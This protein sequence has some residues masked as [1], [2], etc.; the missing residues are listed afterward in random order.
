[1]KLTLRKGLIALL[2]AVCAVCLALGVAACGD[3]NFSE[4]WSYDNVGHWHACTD[5]G[6]DEISGYAEH[7]SVDEGRVVN[8]VVYYTCSICGA[9]YSSTSYTYIV[10]IKNI[11]NAGVSDVSVTLTDSTGATVATNTSAT[12]GTVRFRGLD[13]GNYTATIDEDTIP[14]GYSYDEEDLT[15]NFTSDY[16]AST[17]YLTPHVITADEAEEPSG[18]TYSLGSIVYDHTFTVYYA[19]GTGPVTITLSEYLEKYDMVVLQ[20]FYTTCSPCRQEFPY[21]NE[22]YNSTA[23]SLGTYYYSSVGLIEL[24]YA[25]QDSLSAMQAFISGEYG[26]ANMAY[27]LDSS[28]YANHKVSAY[29]TTVV[30]DRY[31]VVCSWDDGSNPTRSYWINLFEKYIGDDYTPDYV[32]TTSGSDEVSE[33][34]K[35]TES[36]PESG[37]IASQIVTENNYTTVSGSSQSDTGTF[38]FSAYYDDDGLL[39]EYSWPWLI[40]DAEDTT[41]AIKGYADYIYTSNAN[42]LGTYSILVIDVKL[43]KGQV[44]MFD[45]YLSTELD[46]DYLYIQVDTVLQAQLSGV[47]DDWNTFYY[48]AQNDGY[49]Q[50][51]LLYQKNTSVDEEGDTVYVRNMRLGVLEAKAESGDTANDILSSTAVLA[52]PDLLYSAATAYTLSDTK[53]ETQSDYYAGVG[54]ANYVTVYLASDGFYRVQLGS[55]ADESTDPYLLADLYYETPWMEDMSVWDIAYTYLY[56]WDYDEDP[57]DPDGTHG[58]LYNNSEWNQAIEDYTWIQT[59][60]PFGYTPVNEYLATILKAVVKSYGTTS[61]EDNENQWL[62]VCRYFVHY[63]AQSEDHDCKSL[64]NLAK[65]YGVRMP[66]YIGEASSANTEGNE[67]VFNADVIETISPRGFYYS[68]TVA[69]SGVYLIYTDEELHDVSG[70]NVSDGETY[71]NNPY[72]WVTDI[73]AYLIA[74]NDNYDLTVYNANG[75]PYTDSSE[76]AY[77]NDNSYVYAYLEAGST[78]MIGCTLSYIYD[79]GDYDVY[80]R[81]LGETYTYLTA[82]VTSDIYTYSYDE[83]TSTYTYYLPMVFADYYMDDDGY[84]WAVNDDGTESPIYINMTGITY[85]NSTYSSYTLEQAINGYIVYIVYNEDGTIA[86]DDDG[87]IIYDTETGEPTVINGWSDLSGDYVINNTTSWQLMNMNLTLAKNNTDVA[88]DGTSLTGYVQANEELVKLINSYVQGGSTSA[89]DVTY[90]DNAWLMTAYFVRT[91][92]TYT[93]SSDRV[94]DEY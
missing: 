51:T 35:P 87:E 13:A 19:D 52:S 81:Y 64:E 63:G 33:T 47:S 28:Y 50:I 5:S 40:N 34:V 7:E 48:V 38:E 45:Y 37:E 42:R 49:Y 21:I 91:I 39:D 66:E 79:I 75:D 59:S 57:E 27:T 32:T 14:V 67:L 78:Y 3:H 70:Y 69:D 4:D 62:E 90:T 29:P 23:S 73:D 76:T 16:R 93:V 17:V 12:N 31:G 36:M 6:C 58:I 30:I 74:E 72:I 88:A 86:R 22:V 9:Q 26:Y 25:G 41:T 24:D 82:A 8:G 56:T 46:G 20:F 65:T 92:T 80:I 83:A 2:I 84:F 11:G 61:Q 18:I 15:I 55:A 54:Y 71:G 68:F 1:M 77:Y 10:Y 60:S 44:F 53:G 94:I 89:S 43:T 85:L